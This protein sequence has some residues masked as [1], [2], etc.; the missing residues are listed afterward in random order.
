MLSIDYAY[1]VLELLSET[2]RKYL[3]N[4]NNLRIFT[5][6]KMIKTEKEAL[7]SINRINKINDKF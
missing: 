5:L 2:K 3:K 6:D 4:M 1:N 7:G